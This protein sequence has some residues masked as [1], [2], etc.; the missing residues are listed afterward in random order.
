[1]SPR[2]RLF[3]FFAGGGMA[4]IGMGPGWDCVFANDLDPIKCA[5]YRDNFGEGDLVERDVAL[6]GPE[7]L[8]GRA[9]LAWASFPCQD[10]SLAGAR[11]GMQMGGEGARS[12]MFW[13]FWSL[14]EAMTAEGRPPRVIVLENVLG[15]AT[16]NGGRDLDALC[17]ALAGAGWFWDLHAID[18]AGFVPQSRPR[19]FVIAWRDVDAP[20]AGAE[21]APQH[22][23]L[24]RALAKMSPEAAAARRPIA[25]PAPPGTNLRLGD[26]LEEPPTGVA[27][28]TEAQM[29]KL[30][31]MMTPL[32]RARVEE[33]RED[34]R[35]TGS[36]RAG[37]VYRRTRKGAGGASE[38][39]AEVRFDIAGCLR[40]PSGGSSRLT[41]LIAEPDGKLRARLLSAREAA[42]LMGLPEEYRLPKRYN[43]AYKIA[44]DGVAAPVVRHLAAH[45]VEP[46]LDA[47]DRAEAA[48]AAE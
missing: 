30:L 1:M 19:L 5:A 20:G 47:M 13:A 36:A 48:A 33:A 23:A 9:D 28:K 7:D 12:S 24:A 6:L 8:P 40:T 29:E 44:G 42:R 11:R 37:G 16:S 38:Q 34:A 45:A 10:L 21:A 32:Q 27:W 15:L 41:L 26:L 2:R 3:E 35:R 31:G 43:A 46:L 18:A 4:R 25:I 17:A 39:R 22:P 14:I